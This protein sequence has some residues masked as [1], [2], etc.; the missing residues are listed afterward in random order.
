[1]NMRPGQRRHIAWTFDTE[2]DKTCGY[3]DGET[4]GCEQHDSGVVGNIDCDK[5]GPDA[6]VGFGHR[7][8]GA[9]QPEAVLQ[10]TRY[11]HE[12]LSPAEIRKL[13]YESVDEDGNSMRSCELSFEG[14]DTDWTDVNGKDCAWYQEKKKTVPDICATPE[15]NQNCP[16]ACG[17]NAPCWEG[18]G[19]IAKQ[20]TIWDRVMYL[21]EEKKGDGVICVREG[22]DAVADCRAKVAHT[23]PGKQDWLRFSRTPTSSYNN[24]DI[25]LED[26]DVLEQRISPYCSFAASE[27]TRSINAEVKANGGYTID[28]WWKALPGTKIA[29]RPSSWDED[30]EIMRRIVFFSKMSPPEVLAEIMLMQTQRVRAHVYGSCSDKESENIDQG[31]SSTALEAAPSPAHSDTRAR[32]RHVDIM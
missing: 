16:V 28:F 23:I 5:T 29:E 1:M 6:Y 12:L 20:Y 24:A 14:G 15:V 9:Y 10:D 18:E 4:I 25:K 31:L 32:S 27:W 19:G 7:M 30:P 13:A 11:Y 8:P 26:C 3:L 17:Y 21:S 2:T 22:V